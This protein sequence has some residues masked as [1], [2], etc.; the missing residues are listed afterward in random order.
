MQV[1]WGLILSC[2]PVAAGASCQPLE[3]GLGKGEINMSGMTPASCLAYD[4]VSGQKPAALIWQLKIAKL[5][6][7]VHGH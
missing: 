3:T 7:F 6:T 2:A 4:V 5:G 1:I